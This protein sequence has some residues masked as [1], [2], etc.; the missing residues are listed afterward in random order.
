MSC[1]AK[2]FLRIHDIQVLD[3]D[4]AYPGNMIRTATLFL[5]AGYHPFQLLYYREE[6]RGEPFLKLDWSG[7]GMK[8]QRMKG[9]VFFTGRK[10]TY[11]IRKIRK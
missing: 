5:K 4:Y 6:A 8:R 10:Y 1:D 3:E 7:P 2:A 11:E 9:A